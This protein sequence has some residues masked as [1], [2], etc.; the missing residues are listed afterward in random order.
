MTSYRFLSV[1]LLSLS[2]LYAGNQFSQQPLRTPLMNKA[3]FQTSQERQRHRFEGFPV[4]QYRLY[5]FYQRQARFHLQASEIPNKLLPYPGLEGGRRG[6]WGFTNEK[7]STAYLRSTIPQFETM[8]CRGTRDQELGLQFIESGTDEHKAIVVYDTKICGL[9]AAM[10]DS[11]LKSPPSRFGSK[12][13][14]YGFYVRIKGE[15]WLQGPKQQWPGSTSRHLGYYTHGKQAVNHVR[16]DGVEILEQAKISYLD[17]KAV[18]VHQIEFLGEA[19]DMRFN[20]PV[21]AA[22]ELEVTQ[23]GPTE[24]TLSRNKEMIRHRFKLSGKG[25]VFFDEKEACLKIKE[26]SAGTTIYLYST[27]EEVVPAEIVNSPILSSLTKGGPTRFPQIQKT[28]G[29][30]NA[31]PN[32]SGSAYEIDDIEIPFD[33]T[34]NM[35]MTLSGIDFDSQGNAWVCTM[36]GDVWRVS[37]L[38]D[39]LKEV[40]WKRFATG[41]FLPLGICLVND[42]PHVSAQDQIVALHDLNGDNEAD[43]YERFNKVDLPTKGQGRMGLQRDSEGNFY[44]SLSQGIYKLSKDGRQIEKIG[45]GSRNPLGCNV[46]ADGLALSDGSEG[47]KE[48]GT[49]TIHEASHLE[50]IN[51]S[52]KNKRILYLPRGIENSCGSRLFLNEERFGPLGK[53]LIGLSFGRGTSYLIL[54]DANEGT[55]QA[56]LM[57]LPGEFA[58]GSNRLKTN[59]H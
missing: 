17:G 45:K 39:D 58:S 30:V 51:S 38:N 16:L 57:P 13:D 53:S 27:T 59:P 12:V 22:C 50:N 6:H 8:T 5:D 20:L 14:R 47:N 56:A 40:S 23:H 35:P 46:R 49:C 15:K 18:L 9:R 19:A 33:N 42:V 31:D 28:S 37:G 11:L 2:S 1:L 25:E 4:N 36:V 29:K 44:F 55:P 52:A 43:Y 54:R 48:N 7:T 21:P 34:W 32:C 24:M 26:I 3:H 41:I 10:K